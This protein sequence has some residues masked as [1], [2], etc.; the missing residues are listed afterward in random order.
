MAPALLPSADA[1][2]WALLVTA[3]A[4][5]LLGA[6][7]LGALALRRATAEARYRLW[8]LGVVGALALPGLCLAL[9]LLPRFWTSTEAQM[10][11]TLL[12]PALSVSGGGASS[13]S[14]SWLAWLAVPW[15][16]GALLMLA[17]GLRGQLA[18][19]RLWREA[20]PHRLEAWR[21]AADEAARA[22]GVTEPVM[23]RRSGQIGSPM[24]IGVW[25]P[26]VLLP[27]NADGWSP[28]RLR[29]VLLHELA[30]VRRRDTLLQGLAQLLCALYWFNPLAWTAAR[31][32]RIER[33]HACDD[34]VLGA[35][36]RPSSYASDLLEVARR[37]SSDAQ[38]GAI[39][40][41]DPGGIEARLRRVLDTDTPRAPLARWTRPAT[42]LLGLAAAGLLAASSAPLTT[43]AQPRVTLGALSAVSVGGFGG[44]WPPPAL[45]RDADYDL[46]RVTAEV[47]LHLPELE[48]CYQ[49][50]L[51][52]RPGLEGQV[53]IHFVLMPSGEIA[54]QCLVEDTIEDDGLR[55]CV[56]Q[57]VAMS[58]FKAPE[59]EP[60]DITLPLRFQPRQ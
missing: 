12:L 24:T 58:A 48:A 2:L 18:A 14:A 50:R 22:L 32:L 26:R 44:Y 56:N 31:Q 39:C 9:P 11:Q 19:R 5:L 53:S 23:L 3:R 46:S 16:L 35:G 4:A 8:A 6:A 57:L 47:K 15:A 21:A 45:A 49:R 54:D 60:A 52:E 17:R 38:T 43:R 29:A 40:M 42:W 59:A 36:V 51:Q 55:E 20:V 28:E 33:E 41:A 25:S 30:H 13:T 1:V 27:T 34:L 10:A 7:G 37:L